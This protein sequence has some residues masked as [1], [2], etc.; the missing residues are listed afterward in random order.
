MVDNTQQNE[1][2]VIKDIPPDRWESLADERFFAE[3]TDQLNLLKRQDLRIRVNSYTCI[4]LR[5]IGVEDEIFQ[6]NQSGEI[7]A[8]IYDISDHGLSIFSNAC[9]KE[10]DQIEILI[11]GINNEDP[12]CGQVSRCMNLDESVNEIG[13]CFVDKIP[14]LRIVQMINPGLNEIRAA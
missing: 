12:L 14:W 3:K 1:P 6:P 10:G 11:P 13:I 9:L 5:G 2:Q 8:V 7:E 4:N